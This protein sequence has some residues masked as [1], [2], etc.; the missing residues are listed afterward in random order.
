MLRR[1]VT[2]RLRGARPRA[3]GCAVSS[4]TI[5]AGRVAGR[6]SALLCCDAHA[7]GDG[8]RAYQ[9]PRSTYDG[10]PALPTNTPSLPLHTHALAG[11]AH[12][13]SLA[14]SAGR[15]PSPVQAIPTYFGQGNVHDVPRIRMLCPL[16]GGGG[17]GGGG[18]SDMKQPAVEFEAHLIHDSGTPCCVPHD[19][20][21]VVRGACARAHFVRDESVCSAA[22]CMNAANSA[23]MCCSKA[24]DL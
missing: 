22:R 7:G 10:C 19:V 24:A 14:P 13:G 17:G 6:D 12:G 18:G 9:R 23:G 4:R 2:R 1:G 8:A 11:V 15:C 3:V 20:C 16:L 21:C 5:G